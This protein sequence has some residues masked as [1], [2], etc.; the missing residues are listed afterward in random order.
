MAYLT[1]R[2]ETLLGHNV[3]LMTDTHPERWTG[4]A[5]DHWTWRGYL[6]E[7]MWRGKL[8]EI[9]E[10]YVGIEYDGQALFLLPI[11]HVRHI[12]HKPQDCNACP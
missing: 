8:V 10:D 11:A 7:P 3:Y 1:Q 2:L 5:T 4:A 6:V 9:G 12:H